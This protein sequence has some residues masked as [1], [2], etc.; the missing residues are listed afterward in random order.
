MKEYFKEYVVKDKDGE[1]IGKA[2]L[3]FGEK[4]GKLITESKFGNYNYGWYSLGNKDF[5]QFLGESDRGYY[6]ASKLIPNEESKC[7]YLEDTKVNM[8]E[9]ILNTRRCEDI[10]KVEAKYL[11]E[12]INKMENEYEAWG[13]TRSNEGYI[14]DEDSICY[15]LTESAN[16][17]MNV[18]IKK[19]QEILLEDV[20]CEKYDAFKY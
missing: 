2:K 7:F 10:D 14:L 5:R 4:Y 18:F 9:N 19:L 6:L 13:L 15:G 8:K 20:K 16:A 1:Y 17:Y 12:A 11:W 3:K